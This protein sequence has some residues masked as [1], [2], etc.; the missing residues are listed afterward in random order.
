MIGGALIHYIS[1]TLGFI[2]D[3]YGEIDNIGTVHIFTIQWFKYS[4]YESVMSYRYKY[5]KFTYSDDTNGS[6][7]FNDW[8]NLDFSFFFRYNLKL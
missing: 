6:G 2:T 7:D 4:N 8:N 5:K 1:H 3:T